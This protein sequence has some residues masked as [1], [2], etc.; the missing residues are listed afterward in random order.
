MRQTGQHPRVES[1]P[2][3]PAGPAIPSVTLRSCFGPAPEPSVPAPRE[4]SV[5]SLA[6][7]PLPS[8]PHHLISH[9]SALFRFRL[10]ATVISFP[11]MRLVVWFPSPYL[12]LFLLFCQFLHASSFHDDCACAFSL[13][14]SSIRS[15]SQP[16]RHQHPPFSQNLLPFLLHWALGQL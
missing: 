10:V 7:S 3:P 13:L 15:Q 11:V 16:F 2:W 5:L 6:G 9:R 14:F 12:C 1:H 8:S 4:S